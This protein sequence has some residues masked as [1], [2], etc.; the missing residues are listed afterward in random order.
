M[1]LPE[2]FASKSLTAKVHQQ[3]LPQFPTLPHPPFSLKQ[4]Q[5][6]LISTRSA[7]RAVRT[8]QCALLPTVP[9]SYMFL[10]ARVCVSSPQS[11]SD[12]SVR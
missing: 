9:Q 8:A 6:K 5:L 10:S 11:A 4:R 3:K 7:P 2:M 1:Y 12:S